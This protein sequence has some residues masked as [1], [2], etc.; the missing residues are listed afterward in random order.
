MSDAEQFWMNI[1]KP[2]KRIVLHHLVC[3]HQKAK[4]ETPYKGIRELKRDGGWL[5]FGS[6]C[7]AEDYFLCELQ[8]KGFR[9]IIEC[10]ECTR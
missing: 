1:D 7:E 10:A 2:T 6:H 9:T 3:R 4:Q 5:P 8:P